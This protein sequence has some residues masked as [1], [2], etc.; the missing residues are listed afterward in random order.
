MGY[1]LNERVLGNV[2]GC[3]FREGDAKVIGW[4]GAPGDA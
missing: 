2:S 3:I 1:V 4:K